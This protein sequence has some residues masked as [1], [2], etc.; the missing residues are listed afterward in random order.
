MV[1]NDSPRLMYNLIF[2]SLREGIGQRGIV[3]S[4]FCSEAIKSPIIWE[5]EHIGTNTLNTALN[6]EIVLIAEQQP[7]AALFKGGA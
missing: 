2:S 4:K 1:Q 6:V 3:S 7:R 5:K